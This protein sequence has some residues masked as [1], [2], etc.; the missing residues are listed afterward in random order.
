MLKPLWNYVIIEPVKETISAVGIIVEEEK[1]YI[2]KGK[3]FSISEEKQQQKDSGDIQAQYSLK[4]WDIVYFGQYSPDIIK[5][6]WQEYWLI[7]TDNIIC[8]EW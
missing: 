4:A 1:K 2:C 8:K 3:V 7:K 5:Q 6:D